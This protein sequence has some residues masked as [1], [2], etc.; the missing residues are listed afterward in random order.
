MSMIYEDKFRKG[1][2]KRR[3]L[4]N[5]TIEQ[6]A[7]KIGTSSQMIEWWENGVRTPPLRIFY[8]ICAAYECSPNDLLCWDSDSIANDQGQLRREEKA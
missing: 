4:A 3:E 2:K 7:E 6:A 1:A 5:L 8:T